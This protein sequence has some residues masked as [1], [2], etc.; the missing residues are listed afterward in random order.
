MGISDTEL[1]IQRRI[2]RGFIAADSLEVTLE[3]RTR[4][5]DGAGGT[6]SGSPT[7]LPV[8]TLRLIPLGDRGGATQRTTA[9]GVAVTPGYAL[10]GEHTADIARGDEFTVNGRRYEVVFIGENRQYEVKA[11]VAYRGE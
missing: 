11:E 2:T 5:E 8:Q 4:S 6:I 9:D 1:A 3:R 7:V 10:L